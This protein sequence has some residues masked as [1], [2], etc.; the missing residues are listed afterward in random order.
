MSLQLP[1]YSYAMVELGYNV[2]HQIFNLLNAYEYKR[3]K[4]SAEKLFTR[5]P[6]YRPKSELDRMMIHVGHMVDQM[7]REDLPRY[8]ALQ[9]SCSTCPFFKPCSIE[10]KGI[11]PAPIW[12]GEYKKKEPRELL[13][14]V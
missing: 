11:N 12:L 10:L 6:E 14:G 8:K 7:Y 2:T 5:V 9:T 4:P 3:D 13:E 1:I